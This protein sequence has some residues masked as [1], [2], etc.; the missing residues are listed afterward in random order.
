M[1]TGNNLEDK[2]WMKSLKHKEDKE[3]AYTENIIFKSEA[4][5]KIEIGMDHTD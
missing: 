1:I 2:T 5:P 4:G 3:I